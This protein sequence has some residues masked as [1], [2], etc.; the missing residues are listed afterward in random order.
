MDLLRIAARVAAGTQ[1]GG[2]E[3]E[4]DGKPELVPSPFPGSKVPY[5]VYHGSPSRGLKEF[6][7][8]ETGVWFAGAEGWVDDLYTGK[9]GGGEVIPCWVDVRNP[10]VPDEDEADRYYSYEGMQRGVE[11]GF[12]KRLVLEGYDAYMQGGESDSIALLG[13]AG[14]VNALTGEAL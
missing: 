3:T 10:Y 14:I 6:R 7:R 13:D 11:D 8:P 5:P 1:D 9:D 12:W 4:E 2:E